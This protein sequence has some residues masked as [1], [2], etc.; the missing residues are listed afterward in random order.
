MYLQWVTTKHQLRTQVHNLIGIVL[1]IHMYDD[2]EH[3]LS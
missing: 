1:H 3:T 2:K